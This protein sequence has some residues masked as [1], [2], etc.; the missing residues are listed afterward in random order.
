MHFRNIVIATLA[1]VIAGPLTWEFLDREPPYKVI[2]GV[3]V[4]PVIRRG[5]DYRVDWVLD[6]NP[7]LKCPGTVYRFLRDSEGSVWL[8]PPNQA[9]FGLLPEGKGPTKVI[10]S[11][12]KVPKE[13]A[14]GRAEVFVRTT[15][16]CNFTQYLWP[17]TVVYEPIT[18]EITD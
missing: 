4:P 12:H 5:H 2:S 13:T 15:Y 14:L 7:D 1:I 18:A 3:T 17:L 11:S 10:G 8:L 6:V 9:S 16:I